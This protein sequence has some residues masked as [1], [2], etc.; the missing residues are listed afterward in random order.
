M[1]KSAKFLQFNIDS[2]VSFR[3][4]VGFMS[5]SYGKSQ[6]G[7]RLNPCHE[8]EI[9]ELKKRDAPYANEL[10]APAR[11]VYP[12]MIELPERTV[13]TAALVPAE[14]LSDSRGTIR[15]YRREIEV[16]QRSA[17]RRAE[18]IHSYN[19]NG[20]KVFEVPELPII[21]LVI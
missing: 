15:S 2:S 7:N 4:R 11:R 19:W 5:I 12:T 9:E 20:R 1:P 3:F 8:E 10:P 16:R 14:P 17:D 13:E 21:D 18:H 6:S